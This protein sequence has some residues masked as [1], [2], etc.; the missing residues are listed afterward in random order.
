LNIDKSEILLLGTGTM[1]DIPK[2]HRKIVKE[3][4]KILGILISTDLQKSATKNYNIALDKIRYNI[5]IW[6]KR[7][8]S[9]AGKITIIKTMLTSQLIYCMTVL[10]SPKEE[11]WKEVETELYHFLAD[12]KT[13]KIKRTTLIGQYEQGG[14]RMVDVRSQDQAIKTSWVVRLINN[15]GIWRERALEQIPLLDHRYFLRCNLAPFDIP[16]SMIK[17]PIW[18][19]I[20][21]NWCKYNFKEDIQSL[22]EIYNQP[23][24]Y[25][26][27][28]RINNKTCL[29]KR[30]VDAGIMWINDLLHKYTTCQLMSHDE[31]QKHYKVKI[32]FTEYYGLLNAMPQR[33]IMLMKYN[34][35]SDMELLRE[36]E[37]IKLIDILDDS[38][39]PSKII[40]NKAIDNKFKPPVKP[41]LRWR[42]NL[43]SQIK[44]K[45]LVKNMEKTRLGTI[46]NKLRSFNFNFTM[47]NTPYGTRLHKMKI[48]DTPNC[49]ECNT[50]EDLLHL[51]WKCPKSKLLWSNL[52][53]LLKD[54]LNI[55]LVMEAQKCLLN[56]DI[57]GP[58]RDT[59]NLLRSICL[60]TKYFIHRHKCLGTERDFKGLKND[61]KKMYD[62]ELYLANQHGTANLISQKWQQL[63]TYIEHTV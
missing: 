63:A 11:F 28:I 34:N 41:L 49:T 23:L 26:S 12:S 55:E 40:Y 27:L 6:K 30:W 57:D 58:G 43:Q 9:L 2:E 32:P 18:K 39:R 50:E 37:D 45:E 53:Q 25:N 13:E 4:V 17:D 46:N 10:P 52:K 19:D 20:W 51:Y 15:A 16:S 33:W 1:W 59:N 42:E 54:A 47:R 21:T 29:N 7:K 3:E 44:M 60:L 48:A 35:P 14:F 31:L 61:I 36:S 62:M 5:Q 56:I 8:M 24:W 38:P 22:E